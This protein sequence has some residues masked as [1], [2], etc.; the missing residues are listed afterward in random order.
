[1]SVPR[2]R[3]TPEQSFKPAPQ[4]TWQAPAEQTRPL[5][6]AL[7]QVRQLLLSVCRSRHTPPQL[8]SPAPQETWQV[9]LAQT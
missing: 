7:P 9:P 8:V 2:S 1:L 5:A 3:H 4:E 6:Q